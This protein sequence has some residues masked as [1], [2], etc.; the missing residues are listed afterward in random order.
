MTVDTFR[1]SVAVICASVLLTGCAASQ[2]SR[3]RHTPD[4]PGTSTSPTAP[5]TARR[6]TTRDVSKVVVFVVENHSS[7]QMRTEMPYTA[8]L[9][10]RYA[11]A[12]E[13]SALSHPSLGNYIAIAAGSTFGITDDRSPSAHPVHG[14]SVFSQALTAGKTAA[15]YAEGMTRNCSLHN[16]GDRYVVRHN[17]W[18][19]FVDDRPNC[20]RYDVSSTEL[21]ADID[22]GVLPHLGIVVPDLCHDA[23]DCSLATADAWLRTII[24]SV[25]AGLDWKSG[26]LAIVITADEDDHDHGHEQ[27]NRVLTTV[28]HP[29]LR[30]VVIHT[31]LTHL[32]LS[33]FLSEVVGQPPL[34]DATSA[35]SLGDAFGLRVAP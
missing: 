23:H 11:Y 4:S 12:D 10:D 27:G 18:T 1:A 17:P 22:G 29:S 30:H 24:E 13:Y 16:G 19:Y 8:S 15:I 5:P 26:H 33:R 14:P 7:K 32:S 28:V 3:S 6:A 2:G 21:R 25:L 31:P 35:P 34:R 9:A 20:A